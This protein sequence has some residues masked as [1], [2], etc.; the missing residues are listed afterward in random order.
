MKPGAS[1]QSPPTDLERSDADARS[2]STPSAPTAPAS[3]SDARA[4]LESF[5]SPAGRPDETVLVFDGQ[6]GFCRANMRRVLRWDGGRR[7]RFLSLHDPVV[8]ERYPDLRF[9]D[10]MEQMVLIDRHGRRFAGA[11]AFRALSRIVP[12]LWP[13]APLLHIPGSLPVWQ[14]MYRQV[15]IR[16]YRLGGTAPACDDGACRLPGR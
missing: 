10:L 11:A 4:P 2:Q 15:A 8:Y 13:L 12:R 5:P 7:I 6:C 9:E 1:E 14:W 3:A 16:R